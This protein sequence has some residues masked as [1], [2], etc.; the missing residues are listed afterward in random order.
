MDWKKKLHSCF[1]LEDRRFAGHPSDQRNAHELLGYLIVNN[2]SMAEVEREVWI[3]LASNPK[4]H[5]DEQVA[6]VQ[7]FFGVWL[8]G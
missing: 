3:F 2:I 5:A 7:R 1:G 4:L 8:D 6:R